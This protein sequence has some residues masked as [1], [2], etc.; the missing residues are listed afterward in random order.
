MQVVLTTLRILEEVAVRQPI[1]VSE[2]ARLLAVPK[3][4]VHRGLRALETAG[5]IGTDGSE[6]ARWVLRTKAL[7]VGRHVVDGMGMRQ[8]TIRAMERLREVTG[9][10]IHLAVLEDDK[11]VIVDRLDSPKPVRSFYPLGF[12]MPVHVASTGKAIL[13]HLPTAEVEALLDR[14]MT[15]YTATTITK[16]ERFLDELAEARRVGYA[17]NRGE[18]R[19][20]IGSVAAAIL[21]ARKRPVAAMS[22]SAPIQ[23]M[24]ESVRPQLGRLVAS[25]VAEV[26][27]P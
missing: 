27:V 13:S 23:R 18:L 11:V 6:S 1:G 12:T 4:T 14:E 19:A 21:D 3:S 7:D 22:I 8:K 15:K 10:T 9:E 5:W 25:T 20:D 2:L 17:S 16:R 24:P 26:M